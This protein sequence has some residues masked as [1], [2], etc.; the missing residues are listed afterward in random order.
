MLIALERIRCAK[1]DQNGKHVPLQLKPPVRAITERIADHRVAGAQHTG[2]QHEKITNVAYLFVDLVDRRANR[3]Q[4]THRV[5]PRGRHQAAP[6]ILTSIASPPRV[7]R[8][9]PWLIFTSDCN[10]SPPPIAPLPS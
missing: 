7:E 3:Q 6:I 5:L 9:E 8:V 2:G 10:D 4:W 1:H